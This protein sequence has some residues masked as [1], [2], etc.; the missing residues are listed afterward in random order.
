MVFSLGLLP[1]S[2]GCIAVIV[3]AGAAL[4]TAPAFAQSCTYSNSPTPTT[5][6]LAMATDG[7]SAAP[8]GHYLTYIQIGN[9]AAGFGPPRTVVVDTGS[10]GLVMNVSGVPS[11]LITSTSPPAD[12]Y[13]SSSNDYQWGVQVTAPVNFL[14]PTN[15]PTSFNPLGSSTAVDITAVQCECEATP[16]GNGGAVPSSSTVNGDCSNLNGLETTT[17]NDPTN[18][19][20]TQC[21][22][23]SADVMPWM[24]VGFGRSVGGIGVSL[25]NN[26][27]VNVVG[28]NVHQGYI[29]AGNSITLGL[30]QSNVQGFSTMQL[31]TTNGTPYWAEPLGSVTLTPPTGTTNQAAVTLPLGP[32]LVDTGIGNMIV[33]Y[34]S[35]LDLGSLATTTACPVDN[36]FKTIVAPQSSVNLQIPFMPIFPA[37]FL[38]Y[39][40]TTGDPCNAA[41]GGIP[42]A[43]SPSTDGTAAIN[44]GRAFLTAN[45]YMFDNQCGLLGVQA[46]SG[47]TPDGPAPR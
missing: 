22:A 4:A 2:A 33:N 24:G 8:A 38:S 30:T 7:G 28:A 32:V 47:Q 41:L 46:L 40:A 35:S 36:N 43:L 20:L 34:P 10:L 5:I 45:N 9:T 27:F 39:P 23:Q 42:A 37:L 3:A 18:V 21:A 44:T 25:A 29:I 13:Y 14:Q 16:S 12:M 1:R 19:T 17:T 15:D 6:S 31:P 11:S 26:P